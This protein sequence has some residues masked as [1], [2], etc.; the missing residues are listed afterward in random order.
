MYAR[1]TEQR[2][3]VKD[4][5]REMQN[6]RAVTEL[7]VELSERAIDN[8]KRPVDTLGLAVMYGIVIGLCI[9]SQERKPN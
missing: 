9:K 7:I 8:K 1:T 3:I 6:N 5:T 4:I 2:E